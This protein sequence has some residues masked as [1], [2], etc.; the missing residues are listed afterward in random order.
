MLLDVKL[1][2]G[3]FQAID[4]RD[5]DMVRHVVDKENGN[6]YIIVNAKTDELLEIVEQSGNVFNELKDEVDG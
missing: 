4:V 2:N 6:Y 5:F 1:I 3:K